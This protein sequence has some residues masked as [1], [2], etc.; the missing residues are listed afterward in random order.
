MLVLKCHH[1]QARSTDLKKWNWWFTAE[2]TL[3][4]SPALL[5]KRCMHWN[6]ELVAFWSVGNWLE[7][8][9]TVAESHFSAQVLMFPYFD[10]TETLKTSPFH[11][12]KTALK[13]RCHQTVV[14]LCVC[15]SIPAMFIMC[16]MYS[17]GV[18][19]FNSPA[20]LCFI[21]S[22]VTHMHTHTQRTT[23]RTTALMTTVPVWVALPN[24]TMPH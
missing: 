3:L 22:S 12:S 9:N 18:C 6:R 5:D 13:N 23:E 2:T 8:N 7:K 4:V 19:F 21:S 20:H 17:Y 16:C 24:Q 14:S 1:F 11:V 15:V 10:F